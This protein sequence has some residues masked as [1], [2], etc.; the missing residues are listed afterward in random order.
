MIGREGGVTHHAIRAESR[1]TSRRRLGNAFDDRRRSGHRVEPHR[2]V[3]A[4]RCVNLLGR[5]TCGRGWVQQSP[6]PWSTTWT[7]VRN[8]YRLGG[9]TGEMIAPR[10]WIMGGNSTWG[11]PAISVTQ[12]SPST[13]VPFNAERG[14]IASVNVTDAR[15]TCRR[16]TARLAALRHKP[17]LA[18]RSSGV[19]SRIGVAED[20]LYEPSDRTGSRVN[21]LGQ[22]RSFPNDSWSSPVGF[23]SEHVEESVDIQ[24]WFGY[25]PPLWHTTQTG[26]VKVSC[27]ASR[28]KGDGSGCV[29]SRSV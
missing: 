21:P 3:S 23:H 14:T 15:P 17:A 12:L 11:T 20:P 18:R 2:C 5:S 4:I 22:P 13:P 29:T 24:P 26:L 6:S 25:V 16:E 9:G 27:V 28:T 1:T 10:T 19:E 7:P 8:S